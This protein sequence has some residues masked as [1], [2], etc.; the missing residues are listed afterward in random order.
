MALGLFGK[1]SVDAIGR[2]KD[3]KFLSAARPHMRGFHFSWTCFFL[4]FFAWFSIPPL[5]NQIIDNLG[6]ISNE[7][8]AVSHMAAVSSTIVMRVIIGPV[9]DV[10]GPRLAM[11]GLLVF[12]AIP[13]GL[14]GLVN[15]ATGLIVLRFFIGFIGATFVPCQYWT[16]LMFAP[17]TVGGANA[18]AGGWGNLGAGFTGLIMPWIFEGFHQHFNTKTALSLAFAVPSAVVLFWASFCY[19]F[20]VDCPQGKYQNRIRPGETL[21]EARERIALS[22]GKLTAMHSQT[23]QVTDPAVLEAKDVVP[24]GYTHVLDALKDLCRNFNTLVLIIQYGACFGVELTVNG[25]LARYFFRFFKDPETGE[26]Q[27]DMKTAAMIA[28][29]F[30]LMNLFARAMGGLF[31]DLLNKYMNM[32]GRF[33]AQGLCLILEG[34][35]LLIFAEQRDVWDALGVVIVFSVFVQMSEGTSFGIVPF[36]SKKHTG[37]VSG[38]V[39]AG[40]N[41]GALALGTAFKQLKDDYAQAFRIVG[42]FVL[43]S[44]LLTPLLSIDGQYLWPNKRSFEAAR[45]QRE[46]LAQNSPK[47]AHSPHAP[48]Q[49][50]TGI[51]ESG[52]DRISLTEKKEMTPVEGGNGTAVGVEA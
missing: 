29:C 37:V 48:N 18:F 49:K 22:Q 21:E 14:F 51:N 24:K 42:Y 20:S 38:L 28:S 3:I 39:G 45:E 32:T 15:G 25:F 7:G 34:I 9:C 33:I 46:A 41:M 47:Y 8:W 35:T 16:T 50:P 27:V 23:T 36:V 43:A 12:G 30:A 19:F 31:S 1:P 26:N 44:S 11:C 10:F 13:V 40:G 17:N 6:L 52:I 4:A 2:A 5:A